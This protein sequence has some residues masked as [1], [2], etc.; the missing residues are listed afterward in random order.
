M[1][2]GNV[3]RTFPLHPR[4]IPTLERLRIRRRPSRRGH[5]WIFRGR[6]TQPV[7]PTTIWTWVRQVSADAGLPAVP[8]HVLR[9]TALAT[10]LDNCRDLRAVQELA[11]HAWPETTAGYTRVTK[12][13]LVEAVGAISYGEEREQS[14]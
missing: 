8:T 2:K 5:D 10:A 4:L 9:H 13:R 14:A 6:W 1:G 7:H 12:R 11:G 3:T